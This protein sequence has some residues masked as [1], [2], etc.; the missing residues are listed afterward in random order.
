MQPRRVHP[1]E[2]I[3]QAQANFENVYA[4][5]YYAA[6]G[7]V[8]F[9]D[10]NG[11]GNPDI[12]MSGTPGLWSRLWLGDGKGGFAEVSSEKLAGGIVG[13][14][15]CA[16]D[17]EGSGAQ[18]ILATANIALDYYDP[19]RRGTSSARFTLATPDA[20]TPDTFWMRRVLTW[21]EGNTHL[22]SDFDN[23]G[24]IDF[25]GGAT[26]SENGPRNNGSVRFGLIENGALTFDRTIVPIP[27]GL[28]SVA[29]DFDGD[30]WVDVLSRG[31]WKKVS[32][33][34]NRGARRFDDVTPGSGLESM[35]A[36]G[37]VA[38]ADFNND[39]LLDIVCSGC[40]SADAWG[41]NVQPGA[42]ALYINQGKNAFKEAAA[43]SG[44]LPADKS[45]F[46]ETAGTATAADFDNDGWVDLFLCDG[47]TNRVYRNL[48]NGKFLDVTKESGAI[49][50]SQKES[51]NA[52]GD[53][54]NDGR[55]DLVTITRDR[56]VGLMRNVSA[57]PNQWIKVR[58]SSPRGNAE[59]A[60]AR[61]TVYEAGR[62]GDRSAIVGYQEVMVGTDFRIARPL[63][64][65]LGARKQCDIRAAF[66]GGQV[67][68][69]RSVNA[70]QT[71]TMSA[72]CV[73]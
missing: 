18:D 72:A 6:I 46:R 54:D 36:G 48:G 1:D 5:G 63:H 16:F 41:A 53:F 22:L 21:T 65:G 25:A 15:V 29:A 50:Q 47:S 12:A 24:V 58:M 13:Y 8:C 32:L 60:G 56:G 55:V 64:F 51:G 45:G 62:L 67:A 34:R 66:P 14:R 73:K 42:V 44:L 38:V 37:P 35:P 3:A 57:N 52:A 20:R 70:G 39:G 4:R 49:L 71:V 31:H 26:V 10:V 11:D 30:G 19:W 23:D 28:Q 43:A 9:A 69:S 59:G 61:V 33:L 68:E 2:R 27:L 40:A 7:D 17:F